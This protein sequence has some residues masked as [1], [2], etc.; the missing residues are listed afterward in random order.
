MPENLIFTAAELVGEIFIPYPK[1]PSQA[2][3][4]APKARAAQEA[5]GE[6]AKIERLIRLSQ[7]ADGPSSATAQP[8]VGAPERG[9]SS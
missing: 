5:T 7:D 4:L 8:N 9:G 2:Q 1:A 6:A 3:G